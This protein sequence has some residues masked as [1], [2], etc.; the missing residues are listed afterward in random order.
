MLVVYVRYSCR[1]GNTTYTAHNIL[2]N[3]ACFAIDRNTNAPMVRLKAKVGL[4]RQTHVRP[5]I[6]LITDEGL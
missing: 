1:Q 3:T 6:S 4:T 5:V 2:R